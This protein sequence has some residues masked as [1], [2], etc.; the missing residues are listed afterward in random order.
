MSTDTDDRRWHSVRATVAAALDRPLLGLEPRRTALAIVYLLGLL[1]MFL[2]SYLG[3]RVPIND[4][5]QSAQTTGLDTLSMIFIALVTPTILVVPLCYAIWNGGPGLSAVLP[6]VPIGV[7]DVMAGAYVLDLDIAIALTIGANAA[8]L[9]LVSAAVRRAGS[10]RFWRAGVDEDGVL[11]VTAISIVA[12]VAV[13]RFL[14]TAPSY[15]LE[16]YAPL[17]G[18]WFVTAVLLGGSWLCWARSVLDS[19]VD[20]LATDS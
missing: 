9:A 6:L 15:M 14:E 2:G 5:V 8:A 18:V 7:G 4:A 1:A 20:R 3:T 19:R 11:F 16:W 13:G 10:L 17:E 12:A